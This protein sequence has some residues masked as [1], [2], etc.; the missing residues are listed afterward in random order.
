MKKL[1]VTLLV[2]LLL[3]GIFGWSALYG[4]N[5]GIF[6]IPP[7]SEGVTLGLDLVGGSEITYEADIPAD[8]TADEV[9]EGMDTAVTMLRQRLNTLGYTEAN[10]YKSGSNRIIVEIP[11]V[12]NPEEAVQMLGT[13]AIIEFRDY[14][15]NVILSG[16]DISSATAK[17][18]QVSDTTVASQYYVQLQLS[19]AGYE[20]FVTATAE[21]STYTENVDNYLAIVMDDSVI[22]QPFV[23][24][25]LDTDSP[26]ITLGTNAT[27][28]QAQYLAE[29]ISS[30]Q[31]PFTLT[32]A[33]LQSVGA[34]LGEKAL[35]TSLIAGG[36][37]LLLVML[38]MLIK[39]RIPGLIAD[40]ALLFYV[41][42]FAVCISIFKVN[43]SL[44]GIAGIILTIGMAVDANIIIYERLQEEMR[45]GKT[46]RSSVD[47]GFKRAFTAIL[48]SNITTAIAAI[49]LLIFG[50]GVILG[51][52]ETLIIGLVLSM[53]SML[54][55]PRAILL[56][57]SGLKFKSLKAY[58][59]SDNSKPSIFET[60]STK[61]NFIKH[62]VLFAIISGLLCIT[63]LAGLILLPFGISLF[64]FDID[65]VGGTTMEV[66][67]GT[68]V[69]RDIQVEI[70][71]IVIDVS[72]IT[73]TVTTSGNSGT[74]VTIKT[75][76]LDSATRD[77]IF[78]DIAAT[79][80]AD[81]VELSSSNF[82]S[83]A[84][85]NDLKNSAVKSALIAAILILIYITIRFALK[86][87]IAAVACLIHDLLVML[88]F[89]IIFQIPMNM[90]FIAAAL[91]IIGYSINA[92]IVVFDRVRENKRRAKP[93]DDL[94]DI[95]NKSIWQTMMRSIGTTITTVLPLIMILILGVTS[96]RTFAWPL[97]IGV[98]CGGYSSVC[99][100]S[101]I[102]HAMTKKKAK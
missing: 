89:F 69:T 39:Y 87:G 34:S 26:I 100:S 35:D 43:L 84:V 36:I 19:D 92:T 4:L 14:L 9:S 59:G 32:E 54:I 50:T 8:A 93:K 101:N 33:K 90:T 48:D 37:G 31:L 45:Q 62:K 66:E 86:S 6:E 44:A 79:Y 76:E 97:M 21:I 3:I 22:S 16:A 25:A 12:D 18:G 58:G 23:N 5:V 15:G 67:I 56:G 80:G 46:L 102:W 64:N 61:F 71:N 57:F 68:T 2:V 29:I 55:V 81:N 52:A 24:E 77:A 98:I 85:G 95:M 41:S 11:N 7:V 40:L 91:T 75:T 10:V 20:K 38:F 73:P 65:F 60:L 30:G 74:A 47:S 94:G 96:I 27:V 88:S 78:N 17:Y 51:F 53:L 13:T 72:G 49:V 99:L 1:I 82:V 83:A 63:G 28:E 70:E 42:L